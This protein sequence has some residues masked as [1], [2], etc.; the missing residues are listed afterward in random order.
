MAKA[1]AELA[2]QGPALLIR[3]P[4]PLPAASPSARMPNYSSDRRRFCKQTAAAGALALVGPGTPAAQSAGGF[5]AAGFEMG[6]QL[7]T[8]RGPMAKA[9]RAA[10]EQVAA[11]GYKNLE[12]FGFD[13]ANLGYYGWS[14]HEFKRV[15]DELGLRTTTGHYGLSGHLETSVPELRQY[16]ARC[17]EGA[18]VLGQ[19]YITW[20]WLPPEQRTL[21]HFELLAERLNLIGEQLAPAGL[22]VAYHNH[23]FDFIAQDGKLGYDIVMQQTDPARVKLQLDL[24]WSEH[25]SQRSAHELFSLQ[26]GRFVMWHIKDMDGKKRQYTEMGNGSI[27]FRKFLPDMKLAGLEEYFVEQG[28]YFAVDPMTSIATSA[29]WVKKTLE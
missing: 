7:Y 27:D 9:P 26:P 25:S 11:L 20:P 21:R 8:I 29:A 28:D 16:V 15:L 6:L 18:Q 17:A 22:K 3:R 2:K 1:A 19:K 24:F 23:D 4:T 14:A 13:A 5:K 10:L 12:I